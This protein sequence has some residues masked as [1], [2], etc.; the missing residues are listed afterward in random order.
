ME[1]AKMNKMNDTCK[2][3]ANATDDGGK[4]CFNF[5]YT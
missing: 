5:I 2:V 3:Q 4:F 1:R